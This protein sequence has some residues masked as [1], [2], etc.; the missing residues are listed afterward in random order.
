MTEPKQIILMVD[1]EESLTEIVGSVL[2]SEGFT[3]LLAKNVDKGIEHLNVTT[4]DLIIS[5]ITMPGKNGFDFFAH[6]RTLPHLQH[7][8]FLFLTAHSD[9]ESIL[10]GK[11]IGSDDYLTKPV[12][13]HLLLSTIRG[14]L[15]RKDQL[16]KAVNFQT[17]KMKH[18]IFRLIT[19]EMRTPLT[20]ILGATEMLSDSQNDYSPKELT[21]FLHMLQN[22]SKRLN[23]MVD[24]FLTVTKIE[25][26]EINREME[27]H[28]SRLNP[29]LI[30]D[31]IISDYEYQCS[32]QHITIKNLIPDATFAVFMYAPHLENILRRLIDN[33]IKFSHPDGV[34]TVALKESDSFKFS[35]TD[36]GT[37][38]AEDK[39]IVIFQKFGQI[40]REKHEQQGSGL[41]LFIAYHLAKLNG[42]ELSF[43]SVEG[44]G[45]TFYL[46]VP[47]PL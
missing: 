28:I 8:P 12:D 16:N 23:V 22:S 18:D 25:S 21:D 45:S 39:K 13:F 47:K 30:I 35:V 41:G 20:S 5:D 46:K 15:K 3:V 14:K 33:A 9:P 27:V 29:H 10:V 26:G 38:I 34:V 2:E 6:V 7:V 44:K 37:G 36:N 32:H 17:D 42:G 43:E 19:H 40:D 24:D 4:P 11:E 31:R 1:D